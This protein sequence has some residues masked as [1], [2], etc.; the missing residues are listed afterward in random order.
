M[1]Q[2][3]DERVK[4]QSDPK[5]SISSVLFKNTNHISNG[6]TD[7]LKHAPSSLT[8]SSNEYSVA[9]TK[10]QPASISSTLSNLLKKP[11][12]RR[13]FHKDGIKSI[14]SNTMHPNDCSSK[15]KLD[16][17]LI[18]TDET[19][20]SSSYSNRLRPYILKKKKVIE[21]KTKFQ[22]NTLDFRMLSKTTKN[23]EEMIAINPSYY[24]KFSQIFVNEEGNLKKTVKSSHSHSHSNSKR[25]ENLPKSKH[26]NGI[27]NR[28]RSNSKRLASDE[29]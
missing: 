18:K 28:E 24:S 19:E 4:N 29:K 8:F 2:K 3:T 13:I 25:K 12:W 26:S 11:G 15:D 9:S 20:I 16:S 1:K 5:R 17:C 7:F 27:Q 22:L 23:K 10:P 14:S 21:H 6:E